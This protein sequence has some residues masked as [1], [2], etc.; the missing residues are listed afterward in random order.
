MPG[1]RFAA[2]CI[3][4]VVGGNLIL[5]TTSSLLTTICSKK[6][7]GRAL[8][9]LAFKNG[10]KRRDVARVVDASEKR[11]DGRR[12][13]H[14][15]PQ[16]TVVE[17][18]SSNHRQFVATQQL[19]GQRGGL[20]HATSWFERLSAVLPVCGPYLCPHHLRIFVPGLQHRAIFPSES[21]VSEPL[22]VVGSHIDRRWPQYKT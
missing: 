8:G 3:C 17:V 1:L 20:P 2:A 15:L 7:Y 12:W 13:F 22:P 4:Q 9:V 11:G 19:I 18:D 14:V 5:P 21:L 10:C 16:V 6:I